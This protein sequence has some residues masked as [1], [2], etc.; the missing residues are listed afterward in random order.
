[1]I[2]VQVTHHVALEVSGLEA[3]EGGP[4]EEPVLWPLGLV[5]CGHVELWVPQGNADVV[6]QPW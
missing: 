5:I 2:P 3:T 1:M 6:Q 4:R